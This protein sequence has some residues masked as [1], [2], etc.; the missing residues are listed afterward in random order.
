MRKALRNSA[1]ERGRSVF[2]AMLVHP[3]LRLRRCAEQNRRRARGMQ[4]RQ[5]VATSAFCARARIPP[6]NG[7]P[8]PGKP[9]PT[10]PPSRTQHQSVPRGQRGLTYAL[11]GGRAFRTAAGAES[12]RGTPATIRTTTPVLTTL[13]AKMPRYSPHTPL[14][15]PKEPPNDT[16]VTGAGLR[17]R[18]S[19]AKVRRPRI[20]CSRFFRP[21]SRWNSFLPHDTQR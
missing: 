14:L 8:H 1:S 2:L 21:R 13:A 4:T 17:A 18:L 11:S 9:R 7:K 20:P 16:R 15:R 6:V 10:R 3:G 19:S 5:T 12:E